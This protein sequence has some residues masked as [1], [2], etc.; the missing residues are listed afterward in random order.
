MMLTG[1]FQQVVECLGEAAVI[2]AAGGSGQARKPVSQPDAGLL[3]GQARGG[4]ARV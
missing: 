3:V 4:P 1:N 2:G